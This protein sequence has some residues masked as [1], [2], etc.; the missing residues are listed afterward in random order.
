[1]ER[2]EHRS[3]LRH[4]R[5][6]SPGTKKRRSGDRGKREKID[7]RKPS[8]HGVFLLDLVVQPTHLFQQEVQ[9]VQRLHAQ[10]TM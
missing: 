9:V 6:C 1:M 5:T 3:K 4:Q 7:G 8:D 2:G 10:L